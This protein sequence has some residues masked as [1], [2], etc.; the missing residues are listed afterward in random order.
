MIP[1]SVSGA[2]CCLIFFD[3]PFATVAKLL[4]YIN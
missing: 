2:G 4:T 3:K 1:A